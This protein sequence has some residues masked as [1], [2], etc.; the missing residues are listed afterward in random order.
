VAETLI[1]ALNEAAI[2]TIP[3]TK[4]IISEFI[5]DMKNY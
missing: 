4:E 1:M 2:H 5:T 3:M